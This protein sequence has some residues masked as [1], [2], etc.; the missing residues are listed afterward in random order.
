MLKAKQGN[1]K[2]STILS[3]LHTT[4][5]VCTYLES[6]TCSLLTDTA[7]SV[8]SRVLLPTLLSMDILSKSSTT[9]ISTIPSHRDA[10]S[11]G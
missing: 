2:M 6:L 5:I 4:P 9:T 1:K 3:R 8:D 11:T 10:H 7:Y